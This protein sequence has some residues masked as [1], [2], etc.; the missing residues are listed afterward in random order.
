MG[1]DFKK[2]KKL[3]VVESETGKTQDNI[4]KEVVSASKE[5][6]SPK[7]TTTNNLPSNIQQSVSGGVL[8][9]KIFD[10]L[11]KVL[12]KNNMPGEDYMEFIE[13]LQNMQNIPLEETVK[14]QTV[15]ATLSTK[16]LNKQKI[17]E[18]ADFYIKVLEDEKKKFNEALKQETVKQVESKQKEIKSLEEQNKSKSEQIAQLTAEI[19]QNQQQITKTKSL[20]E[21]AS[22]KI[23]STE[24]NFI[25]TF[26]AVVSQIR[27]NVSK[28]NSVK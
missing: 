3:F 11:I 23:K 1:L 7:E 8:D 22:L 17:L 27:T 6:D 28:I 14:M 18:S 20:T 9:Q 2:I 26:E 25:Y 12:E 15:L 19:N 24:N 16:G 4:K 13:A 10:S 21:E 5:K